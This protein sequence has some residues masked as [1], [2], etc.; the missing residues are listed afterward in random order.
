[1]S[2]F[3]LYSWQRMSVNLDFLNASYTYS[4]MSKKLA[5]LTFHKVQLYIMLILKLWQHRMERGGP[6]TKSAFY[7]GTRLLTLQVRCDEVDVLLNLVQ[8]MDSW[9]TICTVF[10]QVIE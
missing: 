9:K 4:F 7:R 8:K 1:M 6:S 10:S 2:L 3:S 5:Q